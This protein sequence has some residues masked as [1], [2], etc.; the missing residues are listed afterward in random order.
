M[1]IQ[2]NKYDVETEDLE[3]SK[4]QFKTPIE[5]TGLKCDFCSKTYSSLKGLKIHK[6]NSHLL[7]PI[8]PEINILIYCLIFRSESSSRT[9]SCL[10][11]RQQFAK[12]W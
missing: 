1:K 4:V 5:S 2:M 11:V 3:D 9:R 6:T 8:D 10:S 12:A 7:V